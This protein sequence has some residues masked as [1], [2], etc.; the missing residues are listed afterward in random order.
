MNCGESMTVADVRKGCMQVAVQT[1]ASAL[2][3]DDASVQS[4]SVTRRYNNECFNSGC[5]RIAVVYAV[6]VVWRCGCEY[7]WRC[8]GAL[9]GYSQPLRAEAPSSRPSIGWVPGFRSP[10]ELSALANATATPPYSRQCNAIIIQHHTQQ[11]HVAW[12]IHQTSM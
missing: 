2:E 12:L 8:C 6:C 3:N 9:H 4:V 5:M 11:Q 7:R 1:C 10:C